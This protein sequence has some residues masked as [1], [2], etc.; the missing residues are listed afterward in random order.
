[1]IAN[2]NELRFKRIQKH[3]SKKDNCIGITVQ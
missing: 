2:V 1:M 3:F